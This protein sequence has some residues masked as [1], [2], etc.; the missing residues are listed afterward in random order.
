MI[1]RCKGLQLDLFSNNN[2]EKKANRLRGQI[3]TRKFE[4]AP[5]YMNF[6]GLREKLPLTP[7]GIQYYQD[8]INIYN[9]GKQ[10]TTIGYC[11]N[12][13]YFPLEELG[14]A[15][16]GKSYV[17]ILD[18][19]DNLDFVL[20]VRFGSDPKAVRSLPDYYTISRSILNADF[21]KAKAIPLTKL[22]AVCPEVA[23]WIVSHSEALAIDGLTE[24]AIVNQTISDLYVNILN[25]SA[26][27]KF[28]VI[29]AIG[30]AYT[31]VIRSSSFGAALSAS[32]FKLNDEITV[33]AF[34]C[35]PYN[36]I[37]RSYAPYEILGERLMQYETLK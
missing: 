34:Q 30:D 35:D 24:E 22:L 3:L 21:E 28:Y 15:K 36:L 37:I 13:S 20:A 26:K 10:V 27:I 11:S 5:Q 1:R 32:S 9:Q 17:T 23:E 2:V 6:N 18:M 25:T 12:D 8:L 14:I 7:A 29:T 4:F 33:N 31:T 16:Y 19:S